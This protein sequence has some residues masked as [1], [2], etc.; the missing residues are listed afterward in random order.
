MSV[1]I[2]GANQFFSISPE[3]MSEKNLGNLGPALA[4]D[5]GFERS[6]EGPIEKCPFFGSFFWTFKKMNE[7]KLI[8]IAT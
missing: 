7:R 8:Q 2:C 4:S 6:E 3:G 5:F 1:L